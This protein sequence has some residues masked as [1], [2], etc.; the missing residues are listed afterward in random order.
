MPV[1]SLTKIATAAVVLDWAQAVNVDLSSNL[2]IPQS[3]A[4][5]GGPNQ[6][7]L[8]PGDLM[9]IRD[10]LY[11]SI[12]GSNN[13]TAEALA[14][15]VGK[16]L[17]LREGKGGDPI[18]EF[19]KNMNALALNNGAKNTRFKNSHGMDHRESRPFHALVISPGFQSM[20]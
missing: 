20:R 12:L 2:I 5:I 10:A 17:L 11:C 9:S 4:L 6:L 1:A 18:K 14:V 16:D 7:G 15:H 3:A 8:V 19:V 13:W